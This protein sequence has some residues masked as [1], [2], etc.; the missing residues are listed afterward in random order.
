MTPPGDAAAYPILES[1][2]RLGGLRFDRFVDAALYGPGGFFVAGGRGAGRRADFVTSVE[3]G[4]LFG[5]VVANALD[6]EWERLGRPDSF[7]VVEAGAGR[8]ALARDVLGAG[9]ACA[10]ALRYVCVERSARLRAEAEAL[11]PVEPPATV[12]GLGRGDDPDDDTV[13]V[14]SQGPSVTVLDGL[15]ARVPYGVILANELL[16]NLPF[17]LLERQDGGWAEVYVGPG[18]SA[19]ALAEVLVEAPPEAVLVAT[20]LA[21]KALPGA[22][23][24]LQE[25][26]GAWLGGAL[27]RPE[28]GKVVVIDYADTTASLAS[29]PWRDWVR[30]YRSQGRGGVPL[31][32]PGEQDV[33]CEVAL[34][35]LARVRQPDVNRTQAEWL[36]GHGIDELVAS[37]RATWHE[38]AAVGDLAALSA[39]SRLGEADALCDPDGL[40]AFRVLEWQVGP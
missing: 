8:G 15:P 13:A 16:D 21:P 12:L 4:P 18:P 37:A 31:D 29:R 32:H 6:A 22:R 35:Q 33:T 7:V 23:V 1:V 10:V 19:G 34:D 14:V 20:R 27:S 17:R 3:V 9:P 30:T 28:A 39:R 11:L 5:A 40:G 38:R 36:R 26:A 25:S 24:P 2:Q